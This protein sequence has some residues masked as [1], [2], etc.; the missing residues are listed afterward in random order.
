MF[1]SYETNYTD[2]MKSE[3]V[4]FLLAAAT[5]NAGKTTLTMGLLRALCR[6]GL[7]VQPFKCGPDY[8][9]P[10]FH[11]MASGNE[12]VNLDA[13][14]HGRGQV[15]T[16]YQHYSLGSNVR[17]VE[18]VMGLFDGHDGWRGSCGQV[19]GW[20]GLP[21]VLVVNAQSAAYSVA[22]LLYGFKHFWPAGDDVPRPKLAGVIFNK[23]ASERHFRMLKE[24]CDAVGVECFG[25]VSRNS[26]LSIPN[27]HLGLTIS[28]REEAEQL[29]ALAASEVERH[30]DLDKLLSVVGASSSSE[31]RQDGLSAPCPSPLVPAALCQSERRRILVA[32]DEAFNFVYRTNLD[33]LRQMGEVSFFSPL[34]DAELPPCDFLYLPG[35]YP[36]LFARQLSANASMRQA[37][38][39]YAEEGGRVFAECGGFMYLCKAID[40]HP[41]CGVLP[42]SA[43]MD[44]ARL[45]LGYRQ[46]EW[47]GEVLR[48]HEFHYSTVV[49]GCLPEWVRAVRAQ[50]SASGAAVD[51]PIY[52]YKN[53]VAGY[54]HWHFGDS[55]HLLAF[56]R[57][58]QGNVEEGQRSRNE[59]SNAD[60]WAP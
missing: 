15:E 11:H 34:R 59:P 24:G 9:D 55:G 45:H 22:P 13:F 20:L 50:S 29:I 37:I 35:G 32:Q 60:V 39:D 30:V 3:N 48:G 12:S 40:E 25:Y 23:V 53:V 4:G 51:T 28:Q 58:V 54:T 2:V 1:V 10:M 17:I 33:A 52:L 38:R 31:C 56:F 6:R 27:R 16:F 57:K 21:I 36:E 46:M 7:K 44:A 19:A 5:S 8:I 49:E 18:G 41:M 26:S 43:T 14:M 42:V 47:D